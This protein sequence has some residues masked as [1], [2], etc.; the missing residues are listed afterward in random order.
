MSS[1]V[2][3]THY[4]KFLYLN[5]LVSSMFKSSYFNGLFLGVALIIST[6]VIYLANKALFF[7][8]KSI[9][10]IIFILLI[11]KSGLEARKANGGFIYFGQIFK[12]MFV[13]GAIGVAICTPFEYIMMNFIDPG[14]IDIYR[15]IL[16]ESA[17]LT[18]EIMEDH[19]GDIAVER[20]DKE[21]EKIENTNPFSLA[22]TFKGFL[23]KMIA[24]VALLSALFGLILKK[25]GSNNSD[26]SKNKQ[27][28]YIV[29]K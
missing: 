9:L 8:S 6:Y 29:N 25:P 21:I 27:E 10:L 12:N 15:D 5:L 11:V 24:P 28:R 20:A 4:W 7:S 3:F 22:N 1:N 14:L 16:V 19:F 17:E 2:I 13:T 23:M 26:D 18:R